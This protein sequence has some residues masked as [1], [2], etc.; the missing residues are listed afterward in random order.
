M[1]TATTDRVLVHLNSLELGGTQINAVDL[2]VQARSHGIHSILV[3]A[4]DTLPD[5][6]SLLDIAADRGIAV[7]VYE[8]SSSMLARGRQVADLARAH[9]AGL[10]H[11]YGSWGGG[12]RPTYWN[13]ARFGRRPWVQ[14]VWEMAVDPQIKRHMPMIVGTG[15]LV[16][17]LRER[18]GLTRL[19][20]PPVDTDL[21]RPDPALGS[22]FRAQHDL[23]GPVI[24]IVSRLDLSMKSVPIGI[25]IEAMR[26]LAD[27]ATLVIVGTGDDETRLR[28][29]GARVNEAAGRAAVRFVGPMANPRPAYAASD[30]M[31]GMGGSA[32]RSLAFGAPL[33][34]HGEGGRSELFDETSADALARYSYWSD[35]AVADP[36]GSIA[37]ILSSLLEDEDRRT[38][39]GRFGRQFAIDR[40]GLDSMA[41]ELAHFYRAA[42]TSYGLRGWVGDLPSE[43]RMLAEKAAR[44]ARARMPQASRA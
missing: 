26:F 35:D 17:D 27:R 3:G 8:P 2:A 23:R 1:N 42:S 38:E 25:V 16:D 40:F 11:V 43:A 36:V 10:V 44:A 34:V 21:D 7:E 31:V 41:R 29:A 32:A 24:G 13:F 9:N 14:T 37:G 19:I 22:V 6:P 20:S 15:Y 33:V 5:G 30:I 12:A 4:A 39:L 28:A 18:P